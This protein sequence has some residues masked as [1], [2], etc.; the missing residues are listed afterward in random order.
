M[1]PPA[2]E[3]NRRQTRPKSMKNHHLALSAVVALVVLATGC[4]DT[5]DSPTPRGREAGT[6]AV[7][8][9][10]RVEVEMGHCFVEPVSFDG[11]SWNVPFDKQFGGGGLEPKHWRGRG[12]MTRVNEDLARFE[13]EGGSTV[14]FRPV[15]DPSVRPVEKALCD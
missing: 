11:E 12:M 8:A 13:D 6:V 1:S 7:P 15:D 5:T 3:L 4:T 9:T 14:V 2:L 10:A